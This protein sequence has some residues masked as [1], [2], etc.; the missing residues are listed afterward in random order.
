MHLYIN[1]CNFINN[2]SYMS[3]NYTHHF[4]DKRPGHTEAKFISKQTSMKVMNS[5]ATTKW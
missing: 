1:T 5:G 2:V 4:S 3:T